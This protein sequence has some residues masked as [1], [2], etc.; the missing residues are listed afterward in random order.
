MLGSNERTITVDG[1]E[2]TFTN[3]LGVFAFTGQSGRST[4][5]GAGAG[6]SRAGRW[7]SPS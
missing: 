1:F 4:A 3:Y 6:A 2:A 7:G 5:S